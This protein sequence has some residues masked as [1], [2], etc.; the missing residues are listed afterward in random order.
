[1]LFLQ[2]QMRTFRPYPAHALEIGDAG[3]KWTRDVP[4]MPPRSP[5]LENNNDE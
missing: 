1:M 2:T 4:Q 5:G 3:W